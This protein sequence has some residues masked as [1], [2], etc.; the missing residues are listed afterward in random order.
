MNPFTEPV[1]H[2]VHELF[3]KADA[4]MLDLL[5][6]QRLLNEMYVLLCDGAKISKI[7]QEVIALGAA[8]VVALNANDAELAAGLERLLYD[9]LPKTVAG[10]D[11]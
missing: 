3:G 8:Q 11:A 5:E 4:G 10:E 9:L 7:D 2:L 6:A 1:M